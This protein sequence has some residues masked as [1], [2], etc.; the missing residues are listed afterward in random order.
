MSNKKSKKESL[1]SQKKVLEQA[2][3]LSNLPADEAALYQSSINDIDRELMAINKDVLIAPPSKKRRTIPTKKPKTKDFPQIKRSS[4]ETLTP[5]RYATK[6][7]SECE[8]LERQK[9]EANRKKR[10]QAIRLELIESGRDEEELK[11]LSDSELIALDPNKPSRLERIK[12]R[13]GGAFRDLL[14]HDLKKRK[15]LLKGLTSDKISSFLDSEEE[16]FI[17]T[18]S[19]WP[20]SLIDKKLK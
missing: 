1:E 7:I 18:I 5:T 11:S 2:L 19:Q 4:P 17:K 16:R 8:E 20:S 12:N 9:R 14:F 13:L 15:S 3:S 10:A 6:T